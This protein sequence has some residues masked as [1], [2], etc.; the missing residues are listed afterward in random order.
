MVVT[1]GMNKTF[2]S[3]QIAGQDQVPEEIFDE[4]EGIE[5][6]NISPRMR[7]P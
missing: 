1:S 7:C 4:C 6:E 3:A 2:L 5:H